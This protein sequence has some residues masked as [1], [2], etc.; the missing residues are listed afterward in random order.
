[1]KNQI[2]YIAL[3]DS[4]TIGEGAQPEE[5]WPNLMVKNL[6]KSGIQI[7]LVANPSVTG[8]TTQDLI[9]KELPIFDSSNANFA[10]L[11][12]GVND[13]VQQV[14]AEKYSQNLNQILNHIQIGLPDKSKIVLITIP[15]FSVTPEGPKYS[16]GR[17]ISQGISGFNKIIKKEGE[18][19]G[20]RVVD[21]FPLTKKM[22][23]NPDH[24]AKDGLHPSAKEYASW[25]PLI[26]KSC[27]STL[28]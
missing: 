11:L 14:S 6:K 10:T 19:R 24:I 15:D 4:Y 3:G 1:M 28:F 23:Q 8:W 25:E 5:A 27:E 20:L 17:D 7:E 2:R 12:I 26:R 22:G 16:K 9:E 18:K 21:I 13:W